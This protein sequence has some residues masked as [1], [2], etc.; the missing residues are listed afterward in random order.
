MECTC[1]LAGG[2][3]LGGPHMGG[4]GRSPGTGW[5]RVD[6]PSQGWRETPLERRSRL[7]GAL[8]P[9]VAP[10]G[11][12][13]G[14]TGGKKGGRPEITHHYTITLTDEYSRQGVG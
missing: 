11:G 2:P 14:G 8:G 7:V 12:T 1:G 9:T 4:W 3:E 13:G 6:G 10:K 5:Q